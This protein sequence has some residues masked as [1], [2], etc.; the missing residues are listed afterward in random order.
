ME[1]HRQET[2]MLVVAEDR[3]LSEAMEAQVRQE[4]AAPVLNHLYL[5]YP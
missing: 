3:V 1:V 4:T 5:A 2:L